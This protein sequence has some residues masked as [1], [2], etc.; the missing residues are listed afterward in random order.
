MED[1]IN[2]LIERDKEARESITKAKQRKIDSEQKIMDMKERKREEYLD[3]ARANIKALE[4]EEK[5]KA[6]VKLK[7]IEG[8]YQKKARRLEKTYSDNKEKWADMLFNK[9]VEE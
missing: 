2:R 9:V 8:T 6:V 4:K 1:M 7:A 3:K 5:I